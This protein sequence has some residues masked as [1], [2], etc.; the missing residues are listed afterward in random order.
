LPGVLPVRALPVRVVLVRARL[1]RVLPV[2]ALLV[3]ARLVPAALVPAR[4]NRSGPLPPVRVRIC[5]ELTV[6]GRAART[7]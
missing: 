3:R 2:R 6:P 5:H 7:L 4:G 1:V